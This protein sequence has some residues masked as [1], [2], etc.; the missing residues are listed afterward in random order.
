[1]RMIYNIAFGIVIPDKDLPCVLTAV[2]HNHALALYL[3]NLPNISTVE[4][5]QFE[6]YEWLKP[7]TSRKAIVVQGSFLFAVRMGHLSTQSRIDFIAN[8]IL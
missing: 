6:V 2:S 8:K 4:G 1:M 5:K 7:F 3:E